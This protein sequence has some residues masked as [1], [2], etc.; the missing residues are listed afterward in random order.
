MKILVLKGSPHVK[1]TS[2]TLVSEFIRGAKEK[3]HKIEE[4]DVAHALLHPCLGCDRCAI[5]GT[6]I[7]KDDGNE[8]LN[9]I[10]SSD[11]LVFVTP[12]YYFGMSAQLKTLIDR[13][14]AKN[15]AITNKHF[16]VIYIACAWNDDDM[17]MKALDAHLDILTSYLEMNEIGRILAKGAGYPSAIK[18]SYLKAAYELGKNLEV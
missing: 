16:K 11:C 8:I 14:Y 17:V 2:N 12:V 18:P 15:S 7:Q 5:N 10:L 9:K 1:G 4:I 3:G 13:F 6:C